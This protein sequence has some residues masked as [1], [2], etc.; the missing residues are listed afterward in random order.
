VA[1]F[2]AAGERQNVVVIA[3]DHPVSE[4]ARN[5]ARALYREAALRPA[6]DE[7]TVRAVLGEPVGETPTPATAELARVVRAA[8]AADDPAVAAR[9]FRSLGE[10]VGV[11]ALVLVEGAE[12]ASVARV[13]LVSEGR[14]MPMTLAPRA[15]APAGTPVGRTADPEWAFAVPLV[16]ALVAPPASPEASAPARTPSPRSAAVRPPSEGALPPAPLRGEQPGK[17]SRPLLASPWFWGGLAAVVS[18]GV[19]VLVLS[20]TALKTPDTLLL[21]GRIAP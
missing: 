12:G 10:D 1:P 19:T 9:L 5:L 14:F 3:K 21:D 8:V 13:F 20:Q 7:A 2:A 18:V 6:V 16:R 15:P 11:L 4:S 17:P